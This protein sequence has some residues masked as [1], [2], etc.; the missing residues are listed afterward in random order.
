MALT[1][2][3]PLVAVK[4][5][6]DTGD[7][8]ED[9]QGWAK[10]QNLFV[11]RTSTV[12][13][14]VGDLIEVEKMGTN[15]INMYGILMSVSGD[16]TNLYGTVLIQAADIT[17]KGDGTDTPLDSSALTAGHGVK[18]H[19]TNYTVIPNGTAGGFGQVIGGTNAEIRI[20]FGYK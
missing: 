2:Y 13:N 9:W 4:I 14:A 18:P 7:T 19:G 6:I 5:E 10:D 8:V 17:V 15:A 20:Q 1:R 16:A 11:Q 12:P 3:E